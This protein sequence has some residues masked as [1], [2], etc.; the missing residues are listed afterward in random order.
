[1]CGCR[2]CITHFAKAIEDRLLIGGERLFLLRRGLIDARRIFP[3]R[4]DRKIEA[5]AGR[6]SAAVTRA[7]NGDAVAASVSCATV[8]CASSGLNAR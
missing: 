1:L 5:N 7:G 6:E 3:R 2:Q 8:I 4:E